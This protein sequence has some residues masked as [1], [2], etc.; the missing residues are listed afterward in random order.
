MKAA[1]YIEAARRPDSA[2]E[3]HRCKEEWEQ[4]EQEY[5]RCLDLLRSKAVRLDDTIPKEQLQERAEGS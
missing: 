2:A 4:A 1:A 3:N 5:E